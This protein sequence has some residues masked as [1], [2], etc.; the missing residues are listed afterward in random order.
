MRKNILASLLIASMIIT[1]TACSTNG[2]QELPSNVIYMDDEVCITEPTAPNENMWIAS[3]PIMVIDAFE[4]MRIPEGNVVD[5]ITHI[6]DYDITNFDYTSNTITI[7]Y[8]GVVGYDRFNS[9]SLTDVGADENYNIV[10]GTNP[11]KRMVVSLSTVGRSIEMYNFLVAHF[12]E[13]YPDI[14]ASEIEE[15][16]ASNGV[17]AFGDGTTYTVSLSYNET[18]GEYDVAISEVW[19]IPTVEV[20]ETMVTEVD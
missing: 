14:P 7:E 16:D 5:Y 17:I 20:E 10:V 9:I 18:T 8:R 4:N 2:E 19:N 12:S 3:G 6:T 11:H 15:Y 13:K 1:M